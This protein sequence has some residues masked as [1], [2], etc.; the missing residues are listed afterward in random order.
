M[1]GLFKE[2]KEVN[3][4]GVNIQELWRAF[5]NGD[6]IIIPTMIG[7]SQGAP[8]KR[9]YSTDHKEKIFK[10]G[11]GI[12][13]FLIITTDITETEEVYCM[14]CSKIHRTEDTHGRPVDFRREYCDGTLFNVW[15]EVGCYHHLSCLYADVLFRRDRKYI[16]LIEIMFSTFGIE[17]K[18]A[19]PR[20]HHERFGGSF[21]DDNF[22]EGYQDIFTFN[23]TEGSHNRIM[24]SNERM[25]S[26]IPDS[27]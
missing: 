11:T 5:K 17:I 14:W 6:K 23:I 1:E 12:N 4:R 19:P 21:T 20:E 2:S 24:R 22:L 8:L 15:L 10:T 18:S 16:E 13:E 27:K 25:L 9:R 3:L 7:G 26:H